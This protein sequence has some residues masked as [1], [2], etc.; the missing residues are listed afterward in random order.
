[1]SF[2]KFAAVTTLGMVVCLHARPLWAN[3][4]APGTD[5][6]NRAADGGGE[7][8]SFEQE[9]AKMLR[10]IAASNIID[11]R[12]APRADDAAGSQ[13]TQPSEPS[14]PLAL[15]DA[16]ELA[17]QNNKQLQAE[18]E[19]HAGAR[20]ETAGAKWQYLPSI[21]F[22]ADNGTERSAPA[23]FNDNNGNR[24][25]DN[26]HP[27]NDL[28]LTIRQPLIDL[29]I[30]MDIKVSQSKEDIALAEKMDVGDGV[31]MDT[32]NAF[33]GI[34]Q[35]QIGIQLADQYI[36]YLQ[37][38]EDTMRVRVDGG[39]ASS[40]DLDR[41]RGR[42]M[43]A[44]AALVDAQGEYQTSAMEF[45]RLT[46]V[47]P[48]LL[49]MPDHLSPITPA[50]IPE[51]LDKALA[52]N[53]TYQSALKKVELAQHEHDKTL[54]SL[55]PKL[56]IQ[57]NDSYTYDAGGAAEGNPV[58]GLFPTQRTQ[59]LMLLA[60]WSIYGGNAV[61]GGLSGASKIREM[62][63]RAMDVRERV[64]QGIRSAYTAINAAR[65]RRDILA[66]NVETNARVA[67]SFDEQFLNGTRSLFDLID[68]YEQ[69]Y[70]ARLNLVRAIVIGSKS[71]FE[72]HRL[73]GDIVPALMAQRSN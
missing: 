17:F 39:A 10:R 55:A 19:K 5:V 51:A 9:D 38:L 58:D 72:L 52:N 63:F 71:A 29:G 36:T 66:K 4:A 27:R 30:F 69:L 50:T 45:H 62:N 12:H 1:M 70:N 61:A 43:K 28:N 8:F 31:A 41:I 32:T 24:V 13:T 60:Q 21:E 57:Y 33:L 16:V 14:E 47:E 49:R 6:Q 42:T 37:Q 56:S 40:S 7:L 25:M 54:S 3:D 18:I 22:M 65:Q 11:M 46:A 53:S 68:A 73:M 15:E 2:K 35:A 59:S 67:Q 23:A 44:E 64:E 48:Q 20:W 26:T 34:I